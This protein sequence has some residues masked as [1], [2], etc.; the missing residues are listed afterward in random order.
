[1]IIYLYLLTHH[2]ESFLC[3]NPEIY[4]LPCLIKKHKARKT[5]QIVTSFVNFLK[6]SYILGKINNKLYYCFCIPRKNP[7]IN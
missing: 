3:G 6:K 4:G 1:M 2:C 7:G 5:W